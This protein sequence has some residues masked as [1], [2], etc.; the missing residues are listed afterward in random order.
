MPV[1]KFRVKVPEELS[2][3]SEVISNESVEE[4]QS[5][6]VSLSTHIDDLDDFEIYN[7]S[8]L[9]YREYEP[10]SIDYLSS[11][12]DYHRV[13]EFGRPHW[14]TGRPSR[15]I[16]WCRCLVYSFLFTVLSG[17]FIGC[18]SMTLM[19]VDL[20]TSELC[21]DFTNHWYKMPLKIQQIRITSHVFKI[22]IIQSW[23]FYCILFVFGWPMIKEANLLGWNMLA[24]FGLA[25]YR[26]FLY[27][28]GGYN[29]KWSTYPANALFA[30]VT[31]FNGF[32][33]AAHHIRRFRRRLILAFKLASQFYFGFPIALLFN[34]SVI[35]YYKTLSE[36][37]KVVLASLAPAILLLP[38]AIIRIS[39]E[40]LK[41]INHP[42]TSISLLFT[43]QVGAS[44]V[45]RVLQA[46]LQD[47]KPF[48]ALCII[49][50]LEGTLDKITLPIRDFLCHK[51]FFN[52]HHS[53]TQFKTPRVSRL[54]AD[55]TITS[56]IVEASA[57]FLSCA[58]VQ[59]FG[60]YYARETGNEK[61][62]GYALFLDF[63]WRVTLAIITEFLFNIVSIKIQTYCYNIPVMRVWDLKWRW[64]LAMILL[65]VTVA[66]LY[67]SEFL[68][69][70]VRS[71]AIYDQKVV[72]KCVGPFQRP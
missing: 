5:N 14:K 23:H 11:S 4:S 64:L 71:H 57:I 36:I 38:R 58:T 6:S 61:L 13:D 22:M 34:Y 8:D 60:Y 39:L 7:H 68:F 18:F 40:R 29:F 72:R 51:W 1:K 24:S 31:M 56:I 16:S 27:T 30:V 44:M 10:L 50:G 65:H 53:F 55:F 3:Y 19:W 67:F 70:A 52:R 46:G 15:L 20:N 26:L 25:I 33:V 37:N 69:D 28:Y 48:L 2:F 47:F 66:I 42:G 62:D 12:E 17:T 32:R 54:W 35:P 21:Y 41:G 43:F 59:V 9:V 45:C 63:L 49:H